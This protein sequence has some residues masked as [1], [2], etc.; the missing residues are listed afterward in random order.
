RDESD[1][2]ADHVLRW[3]NEPAARAATTRRLAE[4]KAQVAVPG[5]CDRAA[6]FLLEASRGR[7]LP[8]QAAWYVALRA[9]LTMTGRTPPIG[10]RERHSHGSSPVMADRPQQ[11][12]QDN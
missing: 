1:T 4:L 8:P 2:I 11:E 7:T 3:L 6:E 9:L 5:A 10:W 12:A